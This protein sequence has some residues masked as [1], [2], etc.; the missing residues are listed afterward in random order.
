[1]II[2]I[3]KD[4]FDKHIK[5]N[6]DEESEVGQQ[7]QKRLTYGSTK[8]DLQVSN[9]DWEDLEKL[10]DIAS[11]KDS[12]NRSLMIQISAFRNLLEDLEKAKIPNLKALATGLIAYFSEDVIDGWMYKVEGK[13]VNAYLVTKIEYVPPRSS[14]DRAY[15]NIRMCANSTRNSRG[16]KIYET[17]MSFDSDDIHGHSIPELLSKR[18][19]FHETPRFK[20]IYEEQIKLF[21]EYQPQFNKQFVISGESYSEYRY[22]QVTF[23]NVK[24]VNDEE[25]MSRKFTEAVNPAWWRKLDVEEGFEKVPFHCYVY[26]FNLSVHKNMWVHV[27]QMKPYVYDT[28]LRDKLVLPQT[29]RDLI[30]ILVEDMN[31]LMEDIIKGKSGGTTI[32]CAGKPG[33][34]KTLSAEVYSEATEKV[35]YKV[36]SGQLGLKADHVEKNLEEIL[37]R[38]SRW[39]AVLLLDEADVYIRQRGN[40]LEHNAVVASFLRT[41][42]YFDGLMFMTTNRGDDVDDAILSRCIAVI[43]YVT[44]TK[45]DAKRIWRVLADQFKIEVSDKLIEDLTHTF[46][47]VSGRDIKELLKLTSRFAKG[48]N[49]P[50]DLEVF[51]QCAQFRG[52]EYAETN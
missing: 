35:L 45:E 46:P 7:G 11:G 29:H 16:D 26:L 42:E 38:A 39:G 2:E 34:G 33:L 8:L 19:Y 32:L 4:Y 17:S 20:E 51:R 30:D 49:V 9:L 1:M 13:V 44:P 47:S 27:T 15:V 50:L 36:H 21:N 23:N 31:I 6:F 25:M 48:K 10:Y 14:D 3:E 12:K 28:S 37:K 18:G 5:P 52:V 43:Q 41:L 40:D 22:E 24:A